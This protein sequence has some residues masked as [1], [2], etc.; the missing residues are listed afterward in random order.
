MTVQF[1]YQ[2]SPPPR[3]GHAPARAASSRSDPRDSCCAR[4]SAR[5]RPRGFRQLSCRRHARSRFRAAIPAETTRPTP[6]NSPSKS[7][8][9]VLQLDPI[10]RIGVAEAVGKLSEL[11]SGY[12]RPLAANPAQ[13][14]IHPV[15]HVEDELT[16]RVRESRNLPRRQLG[17]QI[18]HARDGIDVCAFAAK[19][20]CQCAL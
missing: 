20:F 2:V 10:P 6:Q 5:A 15:I 9:R 11:C 1:L 12:D 17:R 4:P 18:F 8:I 16:D 13:L 7:A 3:G 19:Q 14:V